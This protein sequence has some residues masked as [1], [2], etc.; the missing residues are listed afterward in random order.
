MRQRAK[1]GGDC[2]YQL[3]MP[4]RR[5]ARD[6]SMTSKEPRTIIQ[7]LLFGM[8]GLIHAAVGLAGGLGGFLTKRSGC[9]RNA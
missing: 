5:K 6:D 7:T 1:G 9:S 3:T 8:G 4:G 2:R